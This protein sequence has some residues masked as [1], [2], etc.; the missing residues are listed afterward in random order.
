MYASMD[1]FL[2]GVHRVLRPGGRFLFADFRYAD[3]L[4]GLDAALERAGLAVLRKTDIT[5]NVVR[6]L[7]EDNHRRLE[8]IERG[9]P[10]P[11][12]HLMREFAG[13]EDSRVLQDF[14]SGSCRYLSWVL[15]KPA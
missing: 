4:A 9:A 10:R 7:R 14:V 1:A 13:V 8:L 15:A 11:L 3:Q 5:V 6:A 2:A 12:H